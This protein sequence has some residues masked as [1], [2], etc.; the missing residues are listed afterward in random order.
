MNYIPIVGAYSNGINE[1]GFL[2][3]DGQ[4]SIYSE[5]T[6]GVSFGY[7]KKMPSD[8]GKPSVASKISGCVALN[9]NLFIFLN[10]GN[11]YR[12]NTRF[13]SVRKEK[14]SETFP[15]LASYATRIRAIL[16]G[17]P[18]KMFWGSIESSKYEF[19]LNNNTILEYDLSSNNLGDP[20]RIQDVYPGMRLSDHLR[21][22][23]AGVR[24]IDDSNTLYFFLNDNRGRYQK[25]ANGVVNTPLP[26]ANYW[27]G[28]YY[29]PSRSLF[30]ICDIYTLTCEQTEEFG[31]DE[32]IIRYDWDTGKRLS[33]GP[34]DMNELDSFRDAENEHKYW[35][36]RWEL[37]KRFYFKNAIN[38]RVI[39]DDT[40][41][42]DDHLGTLSLSKKDYK[43]HKKGQ[44]F[45]SKHGSKYKLSYQVMG[46][47]SPNYD[48][49]V[50]VFSFRFFHDVYTPV[51]EGRAT[52]SE[53]INNL[54]Q[55]LK[56]AAEAAQSNAQR[57][58]D[59]AK[60][61]FD[62]TLTEVGK[63]VALELVFTGVPATV[64][65]AASVSLVAVNAGAGVGMAAGM[66]A[67]QAAAITGGVGV[68]LLAAAVAIALP[69]YFSRIKFNI[70][71][72]IANNLDLD[73][74][75]EK[76][77]V[78]NGYQD[79]G[80]FEKDIIFRKTPKH[81]SMAALS[82]VSFQNLRGGVN[83]Q[84]HLKPKLQ[85]GDTVVM[86]KGLVIHFTVPM[87][88]DNKAWFE[89]KDRSASEALKH[90]TQA[91]IQAD[92]NT[93]NLLIKLSET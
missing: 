81:I 83:G 16:K 28:L 11:L 68:A 55:Q 6:K 88:G 12:T 80:T 57:Y 75:V 78:E 5:E 71:I 42:S 77:L 38:I 67:L 24:K 1:Y 49:P 32:I 85:E 27:P 92:G 48:F 44:E 62:N 53:V 34:R 90:W 21:Y 17:P 3:A 46:K 76:I 74:E 41:T 9:S 73:L 93:P 59:S 65:A 51:V 69:I 33:Q 8:L 52:I 39:E 79:S 2:F 70:F 15:A 82:F 89:F 30:S 84:I 36:S 86:R 50:L 35:L 26:V 40:V 10:D 13:S 43:N 61:D 47:E 87:H 18:I 63:A 29:L 64:G 72:L 54:E 58:N 56:A 19:F 91:R 31:Q 4:Y 66:A 60:N 7:P 25:Y 37:N 23:S 22:I 20:R 14:I 45:F